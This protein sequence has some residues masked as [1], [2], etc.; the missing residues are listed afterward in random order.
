M[1]GGSTRARGGRHALHQ[2]SAAALR[3][4]TRAYHSWPFPRRRKK[5][6]NDP[7]T[8]CCLLCDVQKGLKYII[9]PLP[10]GAREPPEDGTMSVGG[11]GGRA[12]NAPLRV[13]V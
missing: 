2:S 11:S 4:L 5:E 7:A 13:H 3:P 1:G 9:Q 8:L 12:E 6:K 10:V